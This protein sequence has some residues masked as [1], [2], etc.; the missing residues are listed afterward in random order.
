MN[1]PPIGIMQGRLSP[2]VGDT[3][4]AFP[5]EHWA[6]EFPAAREAGIASIEWIYDIDGDDV[7]PICTDAGITRL[8]ELQALI[9]VRVESLCADYFM[10]RPLLKGSDA[11]RA[12]RRAK[13]LWLLDRAIALGVNRVVLPF[14]DASK[15]EDATQ[16]RDL[17][18]FL[19]GIIQDAGPGTPEIH[20]ES[21]LPPHS[22]ADLLASIDHPLVKVNYDSGNSSSLGY[23][24]DEEFAA[25]GPRIGSIH[26]KDRV[27]HGTTVPLGTG[28]ADFPKLLRNIESIGYTRPLI[29]QAAR[30]N[31]GEETA[32][33]V[34]NRLLVQS[35][36]AAT[37]AI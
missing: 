28:D 31:P 26:I 19:S 9:G 6:D 4:Q 10:P 2:P 24:S 21:S 25:Y 8:K 35:W 11:D 33:A 36:F 15:I 23:D 13:L 16:S 30:S 29:L 27:L 20:I 12:E 22:F 37:E 7:N 34:H 14:V 18:T 5:A 32:W 3:I 17:A 1:C